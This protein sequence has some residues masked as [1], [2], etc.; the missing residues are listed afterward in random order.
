MD[1][2]ALDLFCGMG[3]LGL[4]FRKAGWEVFGVDVDRWAVINYRRNVSD[5]ARADLRRESFYDDYDAVIG[6]PPC[7]PW[8]VLNQARRRHAHPA[9]DLPLVWLRHV[10]VIRPRVAVLENVP[11]LESDPLFQVLVG[12]LTKLGYRVGWTNL[13]YADYGAPVI[14][15]RLFLLAVLPPARPV[16]PPKRWRG[17]TVR[18]AIWDLRDV[19][20]GEFPDHVTLNWSREALERAKELAKRDRNNPKGRG[21]FGY[22]VLRWDEVAPAFGS[23]RRGYVIHPSGDRPITVRE[24][25]RLMGFP[26]SYVFDDRTPVG[27]RYEMVSDAVSPV[28]SELLARVLLQEAE[29]PTLEEV[30]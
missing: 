15:R 14:K 16:W 9:Y 26:D 11:P 24:A 1:F 3:G 18:E 5:A 12:A 21:A 30:M 29:I 7:E 22:R 19:P 8:S 10:A 28:F 23:V 4:G 20:L 27:K 6:G 17:A 13:S 25:M 2:R